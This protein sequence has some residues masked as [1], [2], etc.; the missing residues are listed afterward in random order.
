MTSRYQKFQVNQLRMKNAVK[1][2]EGILVLVACFLVA[3]FLPQLLIQY[4][5]AEQQLFEQP[6]LLTYLPVSIFVI[7]I[8]YFLFVM[9]GNLRREMEA[10]KLEKEVQLAMSMDDCCG[11]ACGHHDHDLMMDDK[12]D[13]MSVA[14]EAS[15]ASMAQALKASSTTKGRKTNKR[16]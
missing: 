3:A 14:S 4:V 13:S 8:A 11:G 12:T 1:A 16:K 15:T 5:Y 6:A 10:Q 7:G 2:L 9:F